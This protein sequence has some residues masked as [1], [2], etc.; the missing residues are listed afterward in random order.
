MKTLVLRG[1]YRAGEVKTFFLMSFFSHVFFPLS[2]IASVIFLGGGR[3][4]SN[5]QQHLQQEISREI[6]VP[7]I[8]LLLFFYVFFLRQN[9][10]VHVVNVIYYNKFAIWHETNVSYTIMKR[11]IIIL[12][13]NRW[14]TFRIFTQNLTLQPFHYGHRR[15][16]Q[17][18]SNRATL[19]LEFHLLLFLLYFL[20]RP[21]RL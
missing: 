1:A 20:R 21:R 2:I 5:T 18:K 10:F 9:I 15:R 6:S 4:M 17:P 19:L 14:Q 12:I 7:K 13:Q 11:R 3:G 16:P 8:S